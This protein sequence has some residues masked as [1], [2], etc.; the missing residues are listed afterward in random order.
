[1]SVTDSVTDSIRARSMHHSWH[2]GDEFEY[3]NKNYFLIYLGIYQYNYN[4]IS[5]LMNINHKCQPMLVN[6]TICRTA[7]YRYNMIAH[8]IYTT[9][10]KIHNCEYFN[11][12]GFIP[13]ILKCGSYRDKLV[14]DLRRTMSLSSLPREH[15][16]PFIEGEG[17]FRY[18]TR[19]VPSIVEHH[20]SYYRDMPYRQS[21]YYVNNLSYQFAD[22]MQ[23][24][25]P[26]IGQQ[27][28]GPNFGHRLFYP[29][30]GQQQLM[31][32]NTSNYQHQQI[33]PYNQVTPINSMGGFNQSVNTNIGDPVVGTS[34]NV[35]NLTTNESNASLIVNLNRIQLSS[36]SDLEL[37]SDNDM[38]SLDNFLSRVNIRDYEKCTI[39]YGPKGSA[40]T[41]LA[42]FY[43]AYRCIVVS[44][45]EHNLMKFDPQLHDGIIFENADFNEV[46]ASS[47]LALID[48][49]NRI[50]KYNNLTIM[51]PPQ[52]QIIFTTSE[53]NG[54]IFGSNE[55]IYNSCQMIQIS[56]IIYYENRDSLKVSRAYL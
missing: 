43:L 8:L 18:H 17:Q 48:Y 24:C 19:P 45:I 36:K 38:R 14:E 1:M 15:N 47:L 5:A 40:K 53:P 21:S 42:K 11:M 22:I 16:Q 31:I 9:R 25:P 39:I 54:R 49:S 27:L 2:H 50:I 56:D 52:T 41:S 6:V 46:G 32:S 55:R 4:P 33:V 23:R 7:G 44:N 3:S 13:M 26:N 28:I 10:I 37:F 51:I 29:N 34:N 12:Y 30:M 20:Q 35:I